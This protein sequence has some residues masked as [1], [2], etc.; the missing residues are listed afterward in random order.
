[1]RRP[2]PTYR[3]LDSL[4]RRYDAVVA[5]M[6]R[7]V[8]ERDEWRVF[9]DATVERYEGDLRWERGMYDKAL[10][11]LRA[12]VAAMTPM[13]LAELGRILWSGIRGKGWH[14]RP[15]QGST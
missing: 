9:A 12:D 7:V 3:Q 6:N 14:R 2:R 8:L 13:D 10:G 5:T 11:D 4:Q 15:A 1:M